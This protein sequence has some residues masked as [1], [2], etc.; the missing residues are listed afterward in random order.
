MKTINELYSYGDIEDM[1]FVKNVNSYLLVYKLVC[2][3]WFVKSISDK[4]NIKTTPIF[5]AGGI[6]KTDSIFNATISYVKRI[7]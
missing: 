1:S 3:S 2:K 7:L 4:F 6:H 5:L